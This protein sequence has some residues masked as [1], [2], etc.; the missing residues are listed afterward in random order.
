[1]RVAKYGLAI[2]SVAVLIGLSILL[3]RCSW[4]PQ[5]VEI[6]KPPSVPTQVANAEAGP[7]VATRR[8]FAT[9]RGCFT[10]HRWIVFD[11]YR[12]VNGSVIDTSRHTCGRSSVASRPS[13]PERVWLDLDC[14][15]VFVEEGDE[16]LVI[17]DAQ[18]ASRSFGSYCAV[19]PQF[20]PFLNRAFLG[21]LALGERRV[22]YLE[23][24]KHMAFADEISVESLLSVPNGNYIAVVAS[25]IDM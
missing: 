9:V 12:I 15:L 18:G 6:V 14:A 2:G 8:S 10:R 25:L 13:D 5:H 17:V 11:I 22:I 20:T 4:C 19:G 24:D 3:V 1:M 16:L 7:K 21:R 23:S